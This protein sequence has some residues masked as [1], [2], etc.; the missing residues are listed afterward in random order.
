MPRR[1]NSAKPNGGCMKLVWILAQI[2]TPNQMRSMPSL[3]AAGASSGMMMKAISK[4]SRKNDHEDEYVDEHQEADLPSR[5]GGQHLLDPHLAADALKYEAERARADQD[6]NHHRGD[7]HGGR[8]A[9]ID[10]RPCQRAVEG[11]QRQRSARAHGA[12]FGRCREAEEDGAEH[13]EDK[14]ERRDD[15]A[16]ALCPQRPALER[17]LLDRQRR[18]LLRPHDADDRDPDNE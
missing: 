8:H 6:V 4:K 10:Q 9:L 11:R 7:A 18:H 3:S 15:A 2:R 14:P 13:E 17:A 1:W 12:G 5:K 16:Q